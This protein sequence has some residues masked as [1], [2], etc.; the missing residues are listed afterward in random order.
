ME[1]NQI[2][3]DIACL[4]SVILRQEPIEAKVR[5]SFQTLEKHLYLQWMLKPLEGLNELTPVILV[6]TTGSETILGY[7][8]S[9]GRK[10]NHISPKKFCNLSVHEFKELSTPPPSCHVAGMCGILL[11]HWGHFW[12]STR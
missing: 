10:Q 3:S 7:L 2:D 4:R 11:G 9:A 6:Q 1:Q 12:S 5:N 8:P